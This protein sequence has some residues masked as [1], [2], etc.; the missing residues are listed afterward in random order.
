MKQ[1]LRVL[2]L[3]TSLMICLLTPFVQ[4][5][6]QETEKTFEQDGITYQVIS[7]S[8]K[9]VE[10][11]E[12]NISG[13]V[14]LPSKIKGYQVTS[15]STGAFMNCKLK[16][17]I[18]PGSVK[19]VGWSA[20][21]NCRDLSSITFLEGVR[22]IGASSLEGCESLNTITIPH[23]VTTLEPIAI[24]DCPPLK[25]VTI[26]PKWLF[27]IIDPSKI[28]KIIIPN[29]V[30][31]VNGSLSVCS[32]LKEVIIP[33]SVKTI[34]KMAFNGCKNLKTIN[35]PKSIKEIGTM[36]FSDCSNLKSIV[37]PEGVTKI[38]STVFSGCSSLRSITLPNSVTEI[39]FWAFK[40]CSSLENI[41]LPKNLIKIGD[42]AFTECSSLTKIK[43]PNSVTEIGTWA[44][45]DCRNIKSLVL[46]N[47]L[48]NIGAFAFSGCSS[49]I[50][51]K[52]SIQS[53]E[54]TEVIM[55]K[56]V[57]P[58]Y[59][60]ID[61][62][63]FLNVPK[64]CKVSVP[65][66]TIGAYKKSYIWNKFIHFEENAI[67]Y[68]ISTEKIGEGIVNY[69]NIQDPDEV[70]EDTSV[71][72]KVNPAKGYEI[73]SL[74]ANGVDILE[75]KFFRMRKDT[76]IKA[77]F[78]KK[79]FEISQSIK[80]EGTL[81]LNG[82]ETLN[83][84]SYGTY[85]SIQ[86]YPKDGYKLISL[87]A[88]DE[89][90]IISRSFTIK[91]NTNIKAIFAK[92]S[93]AISKTIRGQGNITIQ[94]I[95]DR[96]KALYGTETTIQTDP[97]E[98]YEL[99]SLTANGKD[100]MTEKKVVVKEN[101]EI[102]AIF[103]K[104]TFAVTKA[105]EGQGTLSLRGTNDLNKVAYGTEVSVQATAEEGYELVSLTANGKDIMTEKKVIVKEAT[106]IKAVF[107][108]T[109]AIEKVDESAIRCYPN[110][111]KDFVIVEGLQAKEKLK[112]YSM[113][114][115]LVLTATADEVGQAKLDIQML[116]NGFYIIQTKSQRLK[117]E[118][119]H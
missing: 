20:F 83:K 49:L 106:E 116:P 63:I 113:K 74:T 29:G 77:V 99:I 103:K 44:F 84:A 118:V 111:A 75:E 93:F 9:E 53:P 3:I 19:T 102:K 89:N 108:K 119:K 112:I 10:I 72:L 114:G 62:R 31:E 36:A 51:I 91:E 26:N 67:T 16:S 61:Y 105:I 66:G 88:N 46:P 13:D 35:L 87:L 27:T 78:M 12:G 1:K 64:S 30:K 81:H 59:D 57:R 80:G 52:S 33:N 79:N 32:K 5:M 15:I 70:Q 110:P 11:V 14:V 86:C 17:I 55:P 65:K 50:S 76:H 60:Y 115:A 37:I 54:T 68:R 71:Y 96:N 47:S 23:S 109:T 8:P 101:T 95:N 38:D 34:K 40:D 25:K 18:I 92:T 117:L 42:S 56:K 6:G 73:K 104:K 7:N 85:V 43:L 107:V 100:I 97:K 4:V 98:G 41:E 48:T 45:N 28:E 69:S 82:S 58:D 39:A 21:L 24:S 90:I 22:I 2:G 94:G